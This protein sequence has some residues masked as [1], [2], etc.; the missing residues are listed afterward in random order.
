MWET[1]QSSGLDLGL[2]WD[3]QV[4]NEPVMTSKLMTSKLVSIPIT[5]Y[6]FF[7]T[8]SFVHYFIIICVFKLEL[9]SR[10]SEIGIKWIFL[11]HVTL[12][13]DR[14]KWQSIAQLFHAPSSF[15]HHI[16]AI[17]G[18]KLALQPV[19]SQIGAKFVL[20]SVT[21]PLT[22]CLEPLHGYHLYPRKTILNMPW[23]YDWWTTV[24]KGL[25]DGETDGWTGP[26][27]E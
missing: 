14:L 10:H 2:W 15:V 18:F 9:L 22:S 5:G 11:A 26:F 6:L 19:N 27:V 4:V 20:T 23:W 12:K 3:S 16:I 1:H 7:A 24:Q 8:W 17:C 13:F 21:S 25:T